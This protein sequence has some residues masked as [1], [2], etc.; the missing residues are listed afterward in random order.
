MAEGEREKK[1]AEIIGQ[2]MP[3]ASDPNNTCQCGWHPI[4]GYTWA[5]HVARY[6]RNAGIFAGSPVTEAKWEVYVVRHKSLGV[7]YAAG[8]AV[9][10]HGWMAFNEIATQDRD[11]LTVTRLEIDDFGCC[12]ACKGEDGRTDGEP[13]S[14]CLLTGHTHDEQCAR[15]TPSPR[16]FRAHD[17]IPAG[18]TVL[19]HFGNIHR[20]P[21]DWSI[22]Y[23]TAVEIALP[24]N[25]YWDSAIDRERAKRPGNTPE[26]EKRP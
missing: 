14:D 10:V 5:D 19:D 21:D 13:C 25:S 1:A 11:Q 9:Q 24:S 6:M 18:V 16:V 17:V 4:N 20:R 23:G 26:T 7:L 3:L 15:D 8:S 22:G 12:T 2:H